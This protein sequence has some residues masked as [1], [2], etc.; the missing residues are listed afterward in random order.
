MNTFDRIRQRLARDQRAGW[1]GGVCAGIARHF[2]TDPAFF[3]VG[4]VVA[5]VFTWKV[6][7]VTYVVAWILLPARTDSH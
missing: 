6:A 2:N 3:R 7:V 5:C 4:F 1:L